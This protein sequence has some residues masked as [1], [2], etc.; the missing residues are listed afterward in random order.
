M[1]HPRPLCIEGWVGYPERR[2]AVRR[3][4]RTRALRRGGTVGVAAYAAQPRGSAAA[5][6]WPPWSAKLLVLGGAPKVRTWIKTKFNGAQYAKQFSGNLFLRLGE[7]T[8]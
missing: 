7:K 1:G 3:V 8:Y 6:A 4:R 5:L 2:W